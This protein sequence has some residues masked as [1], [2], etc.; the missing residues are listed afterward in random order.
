MYF[1]Q[2]GNSRPE[3]FYKK[4]VLKN[5]AKITGKYLCQSLFFNKVAGLFFTSWRR[6][7]TFS[8]L[9]FSGGIDETCNFIK[10]ET[11]KQVSLVNFCEI[12][13]N[14]FFTEHLWVP[15]SV[16]YLVGQ[17]QWTQRFF[18]M[19]CFIFLRAVKFIISMLLLLFLYINLW[20]V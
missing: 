6:Q 7:R 3:V 12:F 18:Y 13:N 10:K 5:S 1:P 19:L 4:G 20:W 8:F 15:A 2:Y 14:N 11:M 16:W 17:T 9:T